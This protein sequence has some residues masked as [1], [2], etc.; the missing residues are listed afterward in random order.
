MKINQLIANLT[1]ATLVLA[2]TSNSY[3]QRSRAPSPS[4]LGEMQCQ[5]INASGFYIPFLMRPPRNYRASDWMVPFGPYGDRLLASA[6]IG[7]FDR[8]ERA[9]IWC[10]I[11]GDREG[12]R[13]SNLKLA[14]GYD[15]R[16]ADNSKYSSSTLELQIHRLFNTGEAERKAYRQYELMPTFDDR[17]NLTV[18]LRNVSTVKLKVECRGYS[19]CPRLYFVFDVLR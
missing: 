4:S 3:A 18:D 6:Y 11:R 10:N 12:R 5:N 14:F 15:M 8:G 17:G 13:Y 16:D 7:S 9:E 1:I 2:N 19:S